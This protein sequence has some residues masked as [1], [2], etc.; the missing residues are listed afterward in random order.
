MRNSKI[1]VGIIGVQPGRSF[2]AI[3]HIPALKALPQFDIVALSTTKQASADAAAR[4]YGIPS[5]YANHAALIADPAVDLVV[6]AVKVPHHLQL[7]TA[8]IEAGKSV[9]C[10]WPLGNGLADAEHM[11]E[12]AKRKAVHTAVG[13]QARSS[14]VVNY[15]RDL[16][17]E[18]YVG[19]V[20]STTLIGS[21]MNWGAFME[22]SNEY[23]ADREN[24]AT[25]LTIPFG[26]TVD[27]LCYA[28]GEIREVMATMAVRR[29]STTIIESGK[30]IP[31]TAE[32]QIA[33]SGR[34]EGG[35][36]I[37]AHYRGGM[38][39]GTGLLWEINGSEGD[40]Q[41]TGIGGHAQL[42]ELSLRAGRG[43]DQSTRALEIPAKYRWAPA[44][45]S[46]LAF[47]VAQ[48][49]VRLA[50]DL[51]DGTHLCPNFDVALTRHRLLAAIEASNDTGR[52]VAIN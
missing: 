51:R 42:F 33:V 50:S 5:A 1:G 4:E 23:T 43:Q 6:V 48:A 39:R 14:P 49:Y 34:L 11:T 12:L 36:V 3:G 19:E 20:L 17:A 27:G 25:L 28:L 13:L 2:A 29:A 32:D 40:L 38:T 21:G 18:G 35:A 41:V 46:G 16:V 37:S 7:V 22:S 47:N 30:T 26:H 52:R 8:A 10:E 15:V 24:G 31:M 9:F 45:V 44:S